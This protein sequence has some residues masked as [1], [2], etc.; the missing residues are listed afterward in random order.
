M[1]LLQMMLARQLQCGT[2]WKDDRLFILQIPMRKVTQAASAF[3]RFELRCDGWS[4]QGGPAVFHELNSKRVREK[5]AP[6]L[7]KFE[8]ALARADLARA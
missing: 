4:V 7:N 3:S 5:R 8:R 1:Q 6:N 2:V